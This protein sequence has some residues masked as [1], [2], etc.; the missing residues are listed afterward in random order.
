MVLLSMDYIRASITE[1]MRATVA[2]AARLPGR[3]FLP[4][5]C[6]FGHFILPIHGAFA[7]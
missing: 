5:L 1:K 6:G 3:S 7:S 4:T 2:H